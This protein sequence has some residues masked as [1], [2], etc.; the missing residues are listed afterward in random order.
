[1]LNRAFSDISSEAFLAS[2]T[3]LTPVQTWLCLFYSD[4]RQ[5]KVSMVG[6]DGVVDT[7]HWSYGLLAG[8]GCRDDFMFEL[9][10]RVWTAST[11]LGESSTSFIFGP[12]WCGGLRLCRRRLRLRILRLAVR[13]LLP[14]FR[15]GEFCGQR[16]ES[17]YFVSV[18]L[19]I[20]VLL[21][22]QSCRLGID[23]G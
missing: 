18:R 23:L 11:R 13:H 8:G 16:R 1:M 14:I 4:Q 19:G 6:L 12:P 22:D 2:V 21:P 15:G 7:F 3:H 5:L 17:I 20:V 9:G 10:S